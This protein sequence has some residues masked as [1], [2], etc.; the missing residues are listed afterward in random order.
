LE[1]LLNFPKQVAIIDLTAWK[2]LMSS[3]LGTK[4]GQRPAEWQDAYERFQIAKRGVLFLLPASCLRTT[5]D[6]IKTRAENVLRA[7]YGILMIFNHW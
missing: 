4:A 5:I 2:F 6:V 3:L 1:A 7:L